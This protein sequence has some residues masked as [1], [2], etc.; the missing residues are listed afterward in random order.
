MAE[1][2]F[3]II[4]DG[5]LIKSMQKRNGILEGWENGSYFSR[6]NINAQ[7]RS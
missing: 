1:N 3:A 4:E 5:G 7:F 6:K 2:L